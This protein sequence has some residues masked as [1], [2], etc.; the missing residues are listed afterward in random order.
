MA[1]RWVANAPLAIIDQYI[2]NLRKLHAIA[3]DV[4]DK[5]GLSTSNKELGRILT[6]YS[7][8]NTFEIYDGDHTNHIALRMEIKVLPF[9]SKNLTFD[10]EH[11]HK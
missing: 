11:H 6:D 9:F 7:I 2:S 5:D 1:A 4:G 10:K 8:P 3:I